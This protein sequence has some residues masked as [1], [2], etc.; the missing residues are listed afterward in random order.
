MGRDKA[1]QNTWLLLV[2]RA[3]SNMKAS[4][5]GVYHG[6]SPKY[7]ERYLSEYCYRTNRRHTRRELQTRLL[8][9]CLA[10]GPV[11]LAEAAA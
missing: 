8:N 9:A 5:L 2:N 4:L 7:L 1:L 6:V 3:I 10:M 11:K